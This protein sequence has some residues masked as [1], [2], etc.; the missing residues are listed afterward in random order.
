MATS[1][2]RHVVHTGR[3]LALLNRHAISAR[4]GLIVSGPD[5]TGRDG[6]GR[7]TAITTFGKTHQVIDRQRHAGARG[8]IPVIYIT[9]PPAA[10]P[11]M[12]AA[13]FARFLGLPVM[14]RANITD[15]IEAVCGIAVDARVS[16]VCVDEVHNI[17]LATKAGA[18]VSDALKY[19]SERIPATFVYAGI[20]V[21]RA[22]FCL[23]TSHPFPPNTEW[24]G[25][26]ATLE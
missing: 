13:E 26:I 9:V 19:F 7:T 15:I 4:R 1:T 10:T 24:D 11:R 22:G 16:V 23:I 20:D 6:T 5:G 18:E 2:L 12:V 8:R 3:R 14:T 25:V 17:S 21:G